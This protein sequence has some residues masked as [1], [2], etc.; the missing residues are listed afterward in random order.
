MPFGTP[1][2]RKSVTLIVGD[3]DKDTKANLIDALGA[4]QFEQIQH[5]TDGDQ[6]RQQVAQESPDVVI[7]D[8]NMDG[9]VASRPL[10]GDWMRRGDDEKGR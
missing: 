4:Q 1:E 9:D 6:L 3:S 8:G 2:T 10:D 7:I 5:S